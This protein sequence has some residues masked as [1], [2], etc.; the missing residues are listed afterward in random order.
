MRFVSILILSFLAWEASSQLYSR[1]DLKRGNTILLE[2][3][4]FFSGKTDLLPSSKT[5]LDTLSQYLLDYPML[6]IELVGH[7]DIEGDKK[8]NK[9]ISEKRAKEVKAYLVGKGVE[10]ERLN[11]IG[12]GGTKP[13]IDKSSPFNQRI[14]FVVISNPGVKKSRKA[15]KILKN[16]G[17]DTSNQKR[18]A[19][20]IGNSNYTNSPVLK[21][22]INDANTMAST[23]DDLGFEVEKIIDASYSSML[24]GLKNFSKSINNADVVLFYYA[25]HGIQVG[26]K[27]YILPT[28]VSFD[29][30]QSDVHLEAISL[31]VVLQILEY[32]NKKSLNMV[33]LD[34]CRNNPFKTW[35]RGGDEGL[36]EVKAPSGTLVA[37]ST[38][39]G[40]VAFD[41]DGENGLYTSVLIDQLQIAQ[42]IE[43]V[44]INTR[45]LVEEQSNGK[46]SP[47]EL[48]RL[49]G[50]FYLK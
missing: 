12:K 32:T 16:T 35:A 50:K 33:I 25:G 20:I 15:K 41:G 26:E 34:A 39:P 17:S 6:A 45:V 31:D 23:L 22:P 21:N 47:W 2:N 1:E 13:I 19:L 7:T 30:G 27:N 3:V 48:A 18:V 10:A 14:E 11:A 46:Q 4:N 40:S 28:D 38:S 9:K 44:F 37:Y 8:V 5:E 43:D 24:Q 29:D 42:R 49:R 36:A